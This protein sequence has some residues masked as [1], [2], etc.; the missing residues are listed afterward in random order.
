[1]GYASALNLRRR[2]AEKLSLTQDGY[3]QMLFHGVKGNKASRR[4]CA[5]PPFTTLTLSRKYY[6]PQLGQSHLAHSQL[7]P[8]SGQATQGQSEATAAT[9]GAPVKLRTEARMKLV[10]MVKPF[11]K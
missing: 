5:G 6:L 8:Q 1:M 4:N 10:N 7:S 9:A 11:C 2:F 3:R